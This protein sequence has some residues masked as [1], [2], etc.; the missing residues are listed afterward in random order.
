MSPITP[1]HSR[2]LRIAVIGAGVSGLGA[3]WALR[4]VHDVTVFEKRDRLGGHANTVR[5]DYDGAQ[6]DVDTG[7]IVFNP[8]NYPNL[9]ALFEHLGV[10][11]HRTD[12]SFG[13][14]LDRRFEWSSNG[15]KGLFADPSNLFNLRYLGMLR[16]ILTFNKA[17]QK[18][19]E[20]GGLEG[21]SLGQYL[22][23]LGMGDAFRS[24]YLLPMG[25][26]IWSTS[27]AGMS[28]YPAETF[29]RFFKNHRLMHASRPKWNTV[30]GG[31]RTYVQKLEAD[32][33][34]AGVEFQPQATA[35]RRT[36]DG[37][38]LEDENGKTHQFDEVILACHSDQALSLLTDADEDER[39]LLGAIRYGANEAVLHCD[40]TLTPARKGAQAAWTYLR[41]GGDEAA[42]TYDMNRL[43][44][45]RSDRPL[46][47]TLNPVRQPR[48]ETVFGRYQYDHPQFN[49]PAL[50][51]QRIFN[52]IQGVRK[53]WFAGAWLGYGFHEDGLRAGLR[54][55]LRLGGQIPWSFAEGDVDG[56]AWARSAEPS[57][58]K[59]HVAA[60]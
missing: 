5:I 28:D 46:F 53:T 43:Q 35:L 23:R 59:A 38:T 44:G 47:V 25:A 52:S 6:I 24:Q 55:A 18:D 33:I 29:V 17:A 1:L 34:E 56:G 32:L 31:S 21:L 51:A 2:P 20:T 57:R 48:P 50:A 39:Q 11:S 40:T 30:K 10:D 8:L 12:M 13:F 60:E 36:T 19:L 58:L 3:A 9:I 15:L 27:E 16:D 41:E 4:N 49:A 22:D 54:V 42:V 26:A 7:F 45:I 14:S 37:V